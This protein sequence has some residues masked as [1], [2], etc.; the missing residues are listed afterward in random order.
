MEA[1]FYFLD[2]FIHVHVIY[3]IPYFLFTFIF[4]SMKRFLVS[5]SILFKELKRYFNYL[6]LWFCF[7]YD[8]VR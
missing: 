8:I 6:F 7:C 3:I 4:F 1:M 2:R 5:M